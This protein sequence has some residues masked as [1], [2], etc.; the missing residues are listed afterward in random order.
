MKIDLIIKVLKQLEEAYPGIECVAGIPNTTK[1]S[2]H[3]VAKL[4][5]LT[6]GYFFEL[7][8]IDPTKIDEFIAEQKAKGLTIRMPYNEDMDFGKITAPGGVH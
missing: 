2:P 7:V 8:G 6:E 4:G 5:K 3:F 1:L